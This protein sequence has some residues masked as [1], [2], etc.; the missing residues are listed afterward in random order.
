MAKM[1]GPR[2]TTK[3]IQ[4]INSLTNYSRIKMPSKGDKF[5][6]FNMYLFMKFNNYKKL[7]VFVVQII[8]P[9]EKKFL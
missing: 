3:Q 2:S 7:V 6:D 5:C 4:I 9:S 1:D 8:S